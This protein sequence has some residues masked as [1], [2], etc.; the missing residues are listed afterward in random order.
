MHH[1]GLLGV[2]ALIGSLSVVP[3]SVGAAILI[4]ELFADPPA[5]GGD[6]NHDGLVHSSDDEFIE[7]VN[8]G[9]APVVLD[10]WTLADLVK[11][12]H[13]FP[14]GT[15][16][17]AGGFLVVFGGGSPQGFSQ[18]TVA[19]TG[20]LALNNT[21]D[22]LALLDMESLTID[23]FS[24]GSEGGQDVALTRSPDAT[25]PFTSHAAVNGQLFSPGTTIDGF[26]QLFT[27]PPQDDPEPG[28]P[29]GGQQ[30]PPDPQHPT[31][32]EPASL[33]L[34]GLGLLGIPWLRSNRPAF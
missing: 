9:E 20:T 12:R 1:R 2:V 10:A 17:P 18:A 30:P 33:I 6:A 28:E 32:P 34:T 26:E 21:G 25:G 27:P 29:G 3:K 19:S 31:V 5:I 14:A 4:N 13:L 7:L 24:Y 15:S 22:T 11:I 23:V 8:T 16:I